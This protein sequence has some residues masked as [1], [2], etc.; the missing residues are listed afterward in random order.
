MT[1]DEHNDLRDKEDY[2]QRATRRSEVYSQGIQGLFILNGG[3]VLA[4]LTF[5]GHLLDS[6]KDFTR[7]INALVFG[8]GFYC[9]GLVFLAPV[10]HIRY[11]ASKLFDKTSTKSKGKKY[12][13]C[14]KILFFASYSSFLI[15]SFINLIGF[16]H[17][18]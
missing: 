7:L 3:G 6:E 10:N 1:E 4:L 13:C 12:S 14:A 16:R 2:I 11:E 18:P 5:I 15:G 17:L 9:L 8:G